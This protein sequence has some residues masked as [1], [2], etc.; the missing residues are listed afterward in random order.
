MTSFV[1]L[2]VHTEY[3]LREGAIR[4]RDLVADALRF[5]MPAVAIT[6]TNAMYGAM[7]FYRAA[8]AAGIRPILGAQLQ[9]GADW[10]TAS[11][12]AGPGNMSLDTAVFL[13]ENLEGYKS[14]VHLVTL[15]H[16]KPRQPHV[17]FAELAAHG[18]GV[19]ALIGGGES[20]SLRSFA[21]G[22][23]DDAE[24]WLNAWLTHWPGTHLYVDVQDHALPHE[25][26]GLPGMLDWARRHHV[27]IVATN[28][29]HYRTPA[30]AEL[31]RVLAQVE[32]SGGIVLQ[33]QHYDFASPDEM[34][35]RFVHLPEALENTFV[36]AERCQLEIP[37]G[38][39]FQPKYPTTSGEPAEVVLRKAAEAGVLQR[40]GAL[41]AALRDRLDYE[42]DVITR[43]GFADYFLVVADF[44]RY[45]HKQ[46]ISTGPGRGSAAASLVAYALRITDIDPIANRLLFERFL[47]PERISWPD[48][49]T[50]FHDERRG[51][52]IA[53]VAKRYGTDHVAQIGT[54]GTFAA[55]AAIRDAGRVLQMDTKLVDQLAKLIPSAP[56]MTLTSAYEQ[57]PAIGELVRANPQAQRL[58]DTAA[59]IEGFP[60]HTSVHAAGVVIS[61]VPLTDL[62][63][64]QPGAD[65][66]NVTQY[67]MEDCEF[68]GLM[69]MDFLG[70]R[71]VSIIDACV[72][73]V[74]RRTGK[75]WDWRKVP[76]DDPATYA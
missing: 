26:S 64:V 18:K 1:H 4:I 67:A 36:V 38:R 2:H 68:V 51:E 35:R 42:L 55:R 9:V 12:P 19:I 58:W 56:G 71:T 47:N 25:R 60:R 11:A 27:P 69:K 31:Q 57:T 5:G 28:D 37:E 41:T 17:T 62:V 54:F 8:R 23:N 50:D 16:R 29:V 70:L 65:G 53:Y 21:A 33:G 59:A 61:P 40:Y 49:D 7:S 3:S 76:T 15:A 22:R 43:L 13:A 24:R 66:I 44:I 72:A 46:G 48:I 34:A 63:P 32:G 30:D 10:E 52:V 39:L 20:V 14:L 45:A 75:K 73:A 74:E 6:D